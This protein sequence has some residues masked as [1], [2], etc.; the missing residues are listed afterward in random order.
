M[1]LVFEVSCDVPSEIYPGRCVQFEEYITLQEQTCYD[2]RHPPDLRCLYIKGQCS[3]RETPPARLHDRPRDA[4]EEAGAFRLPEIKNITPL[5]R[6]QGLA[7]FAHIGYMCW[8]D[9][10]EPLTPL[11]YDG[12]V[13]EGMIQACVAA[14]HCVS[15]GFVPPVVLRIASWLATT[16]ARFG[17]DARE[18]A[19]FRDLRYLW[20]VHSTYISQLQ[21]REASRLA[22]TAIAP[23]FYRCAAPGCPIQAMKK[24]SLAKCGGSCPPE[25]KPC[26]CTADC[27][28]QHW[29]I[30]RE[31]CKPDNTSDYLDIIDDDGDPD[32][33]DVDDFRP[34]DTRDVPPWSSEWPLFADREGGEIFIDILNDSSFRKGEIMRVKTRTLS[35]MCLKAYHA[36]WAPV[37]PAA[38]SNMRKFIEN[39]MSSPPP[40]MG[41]PPPPGMEPGSFEPW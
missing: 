3:V 26:Y 7:C 28:R 41:F 18:T 33:V 23:H 37:K 40:N 35:P 25:R 13:R 6:L 34:P 36:V 38:K 31:F 21:L 5:L 12:L 29:Y 16:R 22:K 27:Q 9:R 15:L 1:P 17:F 4:R 2:Y 8:A 14:N 30:H 39:L 32:W 10:S 24:G 11:G 19:H 20:N